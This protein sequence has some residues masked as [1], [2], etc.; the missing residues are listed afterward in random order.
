MIKRKL[1]TEPHFLFLFLSLFAGLVCVFLIPVGLGFDEKAHTRRIWEISGGTFMP[2]F[3]TDKIDIFPTSMDEKLSIPPFFDDPSHTIFG[4]DLSER[5]NWWEL[6]DGNTSSS[7]FPIL[8]IL[9]SLVMSVFGRNINTPVMFLFYLLRIG[10]LL[11]FV[12]PSYFAIK[13]IPH[14]KWLFASLVMVPMAILQSGTIS[15][16]GMSNGLAF[17]FI[18][19]ILRFVNREDRLTKKQVALMLVMTAMLFTLKMNLVFLVLLLFLMTRNRFLSKMQ[20]FMVVIAVGVIFTV[21][22]LG[23]NYLT[24]SSLPFNGNTPGAVLD[25]VKFVI[26]HPFS[27]LKILGNDLIVNFGKYLLGWVA[28]FPSQNLYFPAIIHVF[29]F[30][31]LLYFF[32]FDP[33]NPKLVSKKR[34][35]FLFTGIAGYMLTVTILFLKDA[36]VGSQSVLRV[37]G[38]YFIAVFPLILMALATPRFSIPPKIFKPVAVALTT[39]IPLLFSMA[40]ILRYNVTC[41]LSF[42]TSQECL[43]P[44]YRNWAPNTTFSDRVIPGVELDQTILVGCKNFNQLRFWVDGTDQ[45]AGGSTTIIIRDAN[46]GMVITEQ[47]IKN[48]LFPQM[49]WLTISFPR[50]VNSAGKVYE[51]DVTSDDATIEDA[52]KFSLSYRQEYLN[53]DLKIDGI[54]VDTDLIFQ[55]GCCVK[56]FCKP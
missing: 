43:Q 3:L 11:G 34:L 55:Y 39:I 35:I 50:V 19:W 16:E 27:Y 30:L 44:S 13:I 6:G 52:S 47:M 29:Y 36:P 42:M 37:Q 7:Y 46:S 14:S 26:S 38:R 17:L 21:V 45:D 33:T 20:L 10:C 31:S 40:V 9:P 32:I 22:V 1:I 56:P 12:I 24:A 4:A 23:W 28:V 5:I 54:A 15:P 25:Q 2:N 49:D 53:G 41:G 8:Y 48:E 51:I 18:A